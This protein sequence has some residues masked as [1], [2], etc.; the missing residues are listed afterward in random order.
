MKENKIYSAPS[1]TVYE[2]AKQDVLLSS[3]EDNV[4]A[5]FYDYKFSELFDN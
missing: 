1:I 2:L 3:G 5:K 4:T